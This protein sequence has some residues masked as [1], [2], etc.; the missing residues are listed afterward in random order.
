MRPLSLAAE[1]TLLDGVWWVEIHG[2]YAS[3]PEFYDAYVEAR[4]LYLTKPI[5]PK[6]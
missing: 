4:R 2:F 1:V 5:C 6:V 3:G